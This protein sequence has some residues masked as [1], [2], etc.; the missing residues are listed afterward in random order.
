LLCLAQPAVGLRV[1]AL[2]LPFYFQHKELYLVDA[3]LTVAP[4]VAA[5][6]CLTPALLWRAWRKPVPFVRQDWTVVALLAVS[7]LAGAGVWQWAAY[8]RGLVELVIVPI[9]L[10]LAV[11]CLAPTA[12]ERQ[13]L[14][15][16]LF[17]GGLLVA[18][19][20]LAGWLQGTGVQVDGVQR[21]VGP[22]YSPNHSALY[23]VRTFF[24]GL[25]LM[26]A[27]T[28]R[29]R[30]TMLAAA[31]LVLLALL[32]TGSRGAL[33][34]GMPAGAAAFAWLVLRRGPGGLQ[35]TVTRRRRTAAWLAAGGSLLVLAAGLWLW[36][37]LRNLQT[38]TLRLDLWEATLHLW[39]DHL[40]AGVGPGGFFWH[41]PAYLAPG[42]LLEPNQ[43]H[44][45]N[46][47][48]ELGATW[49]IAGLVWLGLLLYTLHD[50]H[51]RARRLPPPAYW[52]RA[53]ALA[54]LIAAVAHAQVDAFFLLADLAGWNAI[55]LAIVV[56]K[57]EDV[58]TKA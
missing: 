51:D 45:H 1:A 3:T 22:H 38:V 43:W 53:G 30:W 49:G 40:W 19:W 16:A 6:F 23:L 44:P 32:L 31:L 48:L 11:R 27:F 50:P 52:I 17:A 2:L 20:G 41:Y 8:S 56:T 4:A 47:W 5:T 15:L 28:H 35:R 12:G 39:R 36:D 29:A 24:V 13:W 21:L 10:W 42:A 9:L 18:L 26:L 33:L 46:I 55:A 57:V 7:L 34:L 37:R 25:G 54:G 14:A 58:T